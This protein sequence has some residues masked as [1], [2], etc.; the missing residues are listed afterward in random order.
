MAN[1]G[2]V[3]A[4][5]EAAAAAATA[6]YAATVVV[7]AAA[8][9]VGGYGHASHA[10]SELTAAASPVTATPLALVTAVHKRRL[11]T[12]FL[13]YNALSAASGAALVAAAAPTTT[14][15]GA[16]WT[17]LQSPAG[18]ACGAI[19]VANAGL[20]A[21]TNTLFP[22]DCRDEK[23]PT[24]NGRM[25]IAI[26]SGMAA[27]SMA[28]QAAGAVW[29]SDVAARAPPG[30]GYQIA[31]GS[32]WY[33]VASVLATFVTGGFAAALTA[34]KSPYLGL[35]ERCTIGCYLLWCVVF[36][37]LLIALSGNVG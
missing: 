5:A 20:G 1:P 33:T 17:H 21:L 13:C 36:P 35:A 31:L 8:L 7:G 29:S 28:A 6:V 19:I 18:V 11:D 15:D 30:A 32:Q 24:F 10:I 25:H 34:R 23:A 14:S 4:V 22:M 9:R 3:L 27:A 26:A 16:T 37:A 12:A 2:A